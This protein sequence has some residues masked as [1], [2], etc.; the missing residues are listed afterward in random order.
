M[1]M[2]YMSNY[3]DASIKRIHKSQVLDSHVQGP[4]RGYQRRLM[5]E[6]IR[7]SSL[8]P[9]YFIAALG[10]LL[11][12]ESQNIKLG[13]RYRRHLYFLTPMIVSKE[14]PRALVCLW[15]RRVGHCW[16]CVWLQIHVHCYIFGKSA[17]SYKALIRILIY[18]FGN[19]FSCILHLAHDA[20][21]VFG[22]LFSEGI[23]LYVERSWIW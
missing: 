3:D 5:F 18:D 8:Y 11:I 1:E 17:C 10:R 22:W 6:R 7:G 16:Q 23:V 12:P 2:L 9:V 20:T 4:F 13:V 14:H 21:V 19:L 15:F